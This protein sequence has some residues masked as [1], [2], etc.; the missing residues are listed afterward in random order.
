MSVPRHIGFIMDGNGRWAQARGLPRTR[1]HEKASANVR[2]LVELCI[3]HGVEALTLY[4]FSSEN[5]RRPKFEVSVLMRL[6][7]RH[8]KSEAKAL[9][10]QG[11]QL[12]VV[13]DITKL[14]QPLQKAIQS[15]EQ[16][17]AHNTKLALRLAINY[18]GRQEIVRATQHIGALIESGDIAVTDIDE[19][20]FQAHTYFADLPEP[21]LLIRTSGEQRLSNFMLWSLAYAELYFTEGYFPDFG[22]SEFQKAVEWFACRSRRFGDVRLGGETS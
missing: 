20:C 10:E 21:D 12:K 15:V 4:A 8:L 6:F 3:K 2:M 1:G 19:A 5:W 18:G 17:T 13:G 11:V 14:S 22:E 9:H 7:L 16:L